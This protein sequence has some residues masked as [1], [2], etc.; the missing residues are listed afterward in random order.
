MSLILKAD[1]E[2]LT[3]QGAISLER[4]D[5]WVKPWRIPYKQF[6]LFPPDGVGGKA[7]NTSGV[8]IAFRSD[9]TKVAGT[10]EPSSPIDPLNM[11]V[12]APVSVSVT[13]SETICGAVVL[14]VKESPDTKFVLPWD[15]VKT[16]SP[17]LDVYLIPILASWC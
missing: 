3:W 5:K 6:D 11:P 1:D 10:I 13:A 4:T 2:R 12:P 8:R 17:L 16:T 14:K 7:E 9:T 15:M